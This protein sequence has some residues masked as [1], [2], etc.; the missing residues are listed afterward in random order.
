VK[1]GNLP[2][3]LRAGAQ[4]VCIVSDLLLASDVANRTTEIKSAL[5]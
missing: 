5:R 4:R 3:I 2:E 1:L